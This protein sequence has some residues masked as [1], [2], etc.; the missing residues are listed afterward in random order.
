MSKDIKIGVYYFSWYN[1]KHWSLTPHKHTPYIGE[2]DSADPKTTEW[3]MELI[4]ESGIDYVIFDLV[5]TTDWTFETMQASVENAIKELKKLGLS[6]SFLIDTHVGPPN[7]LREKQSKLGA[8]G[9]LIRY[10]ESR[11]WDEGLV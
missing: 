6:W 11:G 5:P 10:I 8:M 3:Q 4:K 7:V 1:E 2:Y 9:E